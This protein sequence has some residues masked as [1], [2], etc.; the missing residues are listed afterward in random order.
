M[1]KPCSACVYIPP[2]LPYV[3]LSLLNV[4][5]MFVCCVLVCCGVLCCAVLCNQCYADDV[6]LCSPGRNYHYAMQEVRNTQDRVH[7]RLRADVDAV[8]KSV[9]A[10]LRDSEAQGGSSS[11]KMGE[12]DKKIV[13]LLTDF[14]QTSGA[15]VLTEWQDLLPRLISR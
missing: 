9:L 13:H 12:D 15:Y 6:L 3:C 8:E 10:L 14:V 2:Y 5:Y 11:A 7:A 1:Y 4:L